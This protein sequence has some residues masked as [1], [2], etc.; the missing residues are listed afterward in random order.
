MRHT[1]EVFHDL[2]SVEVDRATAVIA[3]KHGI[4]RVQALDRA[5]GVVRGS[6]D[7]VHAPTFVSPNPGT[8]AAGSYS[9]I[10]FFLI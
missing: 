8:S 3:G 9:P 5:L 6:S 10:N 1:P 4:D 2:R 7:L